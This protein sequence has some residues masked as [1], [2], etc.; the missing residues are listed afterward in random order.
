M[1]TTVLEYR[2][3]SIRF[4]WL[5]GRYWV[6]S[7]DLCRALGYNNPVNEPT[8]LL[9]YIDKTL[10]VS[11]HRRLESIPRKMWLYDLVG[12]EFAFWPRLRMYANKK[13]E[14][15]PLVLKILEKKEL[16]DF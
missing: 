6:S 10:D 15:K 11:D 1:K 7:A 4:I 8:K 3:V 5:D 14:L 13:A 2:G 9:P 12:F 16:H